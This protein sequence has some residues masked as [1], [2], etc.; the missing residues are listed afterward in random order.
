MSGLGVRTV[1]M[2]CHNKIEFCVRSERQPYALPAAKSSSLFP[3]LQSTRILDQIR[4]RIRYLHFSK[5]TE[6]EYLFWIRF[7]IRWSGMRHPRGMGAAEVVSLL[8]RDEV[9]RV[10]KIAGRGVISPLDRLYSGD[11]ALWS[12]RVACTHST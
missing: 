6:E 2:Y 4:E 9:A 7:F 3:P 5:S 8:T 12:I 10:L 1:F 11:N